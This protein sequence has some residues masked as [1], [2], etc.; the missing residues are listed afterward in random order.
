M[1]NSCNWLKFNPSVPFAP[2][3]PRASR[4]INLS[5]HFSIHYIIYL[6]ILL[7]QG[8]AV[9]E[10]MLTLSEG[11]IKELSL[12]IGFDRGKIERALPNYRVSKSSDN[13][14]ILIQSGNELIITLHRLEKSL[15]NIEVHSNK[16]K[17]L[18][19]HNIGDSLHA[20]YGES[21]PHCGRSDEGSKLVCAAPD[22]NKIIYVFISD[23]LGS[24]EQKLVSIF[25]SYEWFGLHNK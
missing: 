18:L 22:S 3:V 17:N 25:W 12:E 1:T 5:M 2:S 24:G 21:M 23:S 20:V 15:F 14:E 11:G 16:V 8:V 4:K 19:G 6:F 13:N 7:Y 9:S 10:E